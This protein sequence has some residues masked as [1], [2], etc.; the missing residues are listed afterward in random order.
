[1]EVDL[2]HGLSQIVPR[3]TAKHYLVLGTMEKKILREGLNGKAK[4][5]A[6]MLEHVADFKRQFE[7]QYEP[8]GWY[9]APQG[10]KRT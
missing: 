8:G 6:A 3:V 4:S 10:P 1:L 9:P 7:L 5:L 2:A